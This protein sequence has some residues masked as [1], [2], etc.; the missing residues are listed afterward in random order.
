MEKG[1]RPALLSLCPSL[2]ATTLHVVIQ[3]VK[4]NYKREIK[5][6]A[7]VGERKGK[8]RVHG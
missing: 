3:R 8:G 7:Y 6:I 2:Y 4:I 5:V 1:C